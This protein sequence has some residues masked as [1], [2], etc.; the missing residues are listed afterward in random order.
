[1]KVKDFTFPF[2][3]TPPNKRRLVLRLFL[4]NPVG[5]PAPDFPS[6]EG[7][8]HHRGRLTAEYVMQNIG[9]EAQRA[10]GLAKYDADNVSGV[11]PQE[12]EMLKKANEILGFV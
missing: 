10:M 9:L 5:V 6:G 8:S 11:P 2:Q 3:K 7:E 4:F 12:R 1:M